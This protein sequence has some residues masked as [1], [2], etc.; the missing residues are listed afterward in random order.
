MKLG[1]VVFDWAGTIVDHGSRA[2]VAA[3]QDAFAG[4]GLVVTVAEVRLSMGI[5]KKD[6]IRCI[7]EIPR[8]REEWVRQYGTNPRET[9][10]EALYAKF[11]PKQFDCLGSFASAIAGVP[12]TFE[13]LRSRGVKIGSTTG[14]TRPMLEFL[15]DRTREQGFAPDCAICPGDVPGGGRPAPWMCYLN[16]IRLEVSPLWAM[17]KIGDTPSDVAEGFNAGMWTIGVT[18]T[19]NEAGLTVEEWD[20][21]TVGERSAVIAGARKRLLDA[22]A[23][24]LVESAG[25]CLETIDEI[26]GRISSGERP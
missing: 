8:V 1:G 13:G 24:Y 18:R 12:G 23:H 25:E 21:A 15:V 3:L 17:V 5:A 6:H 2:P 14:Y 20:A 10:V 4:A 7:L 19:G 22:G 26:A 9:D 16:A 11:I